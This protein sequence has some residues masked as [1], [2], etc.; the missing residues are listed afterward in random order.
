M[1][2]QRRWAGDDRNG[3]W[4]YEVAQRFDKDFQPTDPIHFSTFQLYSTFFLS[5][6]FKKK[7]QLNNG[8]VVNVFL[9]KSMVSILQI[10]KNVKLAILHLVF[11]DKLFG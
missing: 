9:M 2:I 10:H 3:F 1:V 4:E 7:P 11:V 8:D 6:S 5:Y